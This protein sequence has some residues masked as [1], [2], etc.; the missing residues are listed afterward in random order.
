MRLVR[1]PFRLDT[2][3][4]VDAKAMTATTTMARYSASPVDMSDLLADHDHD[5]CSWAP[6]ALI[7]VNRNAG[8]SP[9]FCGVYGFEPDQCARSKC[10]AKLAPL[11]VDPRRPRRTLMMRKVRLELARCHEF[12]E[13]SR[14][15][16]YELHLPLTP[17]GRL[18]R[19]G[20]LQHRHDNS[21]SFRRFWGDVMEHGQLRH[22]RRGWAL[23][24]EPKSGADEVI[25]RGD[26]HRFGAGEYVSIREQDGVTRTFRV[27]AVN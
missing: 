7:Y 8:S 22:D 25:F 26:D 24:F 4:S 5:Y 2:Q 9:R 14:N 10:L 16:G 11:V 18:D 12:P 23:A 15:H 13:G 17:D 21:N 27:A 1:Y 20:W 19:G 6:G 3:A